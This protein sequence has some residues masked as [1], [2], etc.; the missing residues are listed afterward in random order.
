MSFIPNLDFIISKYLIYLW[1][2]H[3]LFK[4]LPCWFL[5]FECKFVWLLLHYW[6]CQLLGIVLNY[7]GWVLVV[8][9][10]WKEKKI[11]KIDLNLKKSDLN[12]INPIFFKKSKKSPTLLESEFSKFSSKKQEGE[13]FIH[14]LNMVALP[15]SS[16]LLTSKCWLRMKCKAS[17]ILFLV[18]GGF[19]SYRAA[20]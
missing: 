17:L 15:E 2:P 7:F 13:T 4:I 5:L 20:P 3:N 16:L 10:G 18:R 1:F 9:G 14:S 12:Q 11:K 8:L 19:L 6:N